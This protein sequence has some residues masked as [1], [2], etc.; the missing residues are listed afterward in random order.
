MGEND[1]WTLI[2]EGWL[3]GTYT[4]T[5]PRPTC[6]GMLARTAFRWLGHGKAPTISLTV[7]DPSGGVNPYTTTQTIIA[8]TKQGK[9]TWVRLCM[10]NHSEPFG[11]FTFTISG[12]GYIR[13]GADVQPQE[14]D[15]NAC[16]WWPPSIGSWGL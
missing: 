6:M 5:N 7:T 15:A 3:D 16:P 4:V 1:E 2:A 8:A 9:P 12:T 10:T 13:F 14:F 11:T